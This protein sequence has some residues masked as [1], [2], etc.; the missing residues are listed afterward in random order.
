MVKFELYHKL[1][2]IQ[3]GID[4]YQTLPKL[5]GCVSSAEKFEKL[6]ESLGAIN[7]GTLKNQDAT[8]GKILD[9]FIKLRSTLERE[10]EME[11]ET[12]KSMGR[13][14][15]KAKGKKEVKTLK[16]PADN[17]LVLFFSGHSHEKREGGQMSHYI[18]PTNFDKDN[19]LSTA[20]NLFE[21]KQKIGTYNCKQ[22]LFILDCPFSKRVL[23]R[24]VENF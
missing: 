6:F 8:N 14:S 12:T 11:K 16:E 7:V 2:T 19:L 20:I 18:C 3:I 1:Y 9:T 15:L 22:V 4:N 24:F 13:R 10:V 5:E 23:L 17:L 21:L